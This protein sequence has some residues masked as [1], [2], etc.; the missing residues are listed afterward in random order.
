MLTS[1]P[2]CAEVINDYM[3]RRDGG[4]KIGHLGAP[5]QNCHRFSNSALTL[6]R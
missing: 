5:G 3:L 1:T 4:A 6:F 2:N